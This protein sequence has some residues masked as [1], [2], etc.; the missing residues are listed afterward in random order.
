MDMVNTFHKD[1][2]IKQYE[3]CRDSE[4]AKYENMIKEKDCLL[5]PGSVVNDCCLIMKKTPYLKDYKLVFDLD[6]NSPHD[7]PVIARIAHK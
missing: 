1:Y 2:V 5:M 4:I 6:E 3:A 7:A